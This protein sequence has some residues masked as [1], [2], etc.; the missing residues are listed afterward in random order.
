MYL[1]YWSSGN[2]EV[3]KLLHFSK[4]LQIVSVKI[5]LTLQATSSGNQNIETCGFEIHSPN[6]I[7][8]QL[9]GLWKIIQGIFL[10]QWYE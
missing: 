8:N 9:Q 1:G 7:K 10:K 6:P 2:I 3:P 5:I 4:Y